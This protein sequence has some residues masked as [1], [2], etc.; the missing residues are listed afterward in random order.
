MVFPWCD[1]MKIDN[2]NFR[3][4]YCINKK[5]SSKNRTRLIWDGNDNYKTN[6]HRC[7]I[8]VTYGEEGCNNNTRSVA[9]HCVP[10][11]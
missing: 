1:R 4:I 7:L 8:H 5:F 3:G 6:S 11:R 10:S 2:K 9:G